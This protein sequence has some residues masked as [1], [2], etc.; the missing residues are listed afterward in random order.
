MQILA[1]VRSRA[2]FERLPMRNGNFSIQM[3]SFDQTCTTFAPKNAPNLHHICTADESPS[4]I[5]AR[6]YAGSLNAHIASP[7]CFANEQMDRV[8]CCTIIYWSYKRLEDQTDVRT[9]EAHWRSRIS[10]DKIQLAQINQVK[11]VILLMKIIK[12][13]D[14]Y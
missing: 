2:Y 9:W 14:F 7:H 5:S 1:D 12:S 4:M 13:I 10:S 3:M 6:L 11:E 8:V